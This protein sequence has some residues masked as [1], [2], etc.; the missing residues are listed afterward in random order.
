MCLTHAPPVPVQLQLHTNND[1]GEQTNNDTAADAGGASER[2]A[3]FPTRPLQLLPRHIGAVF[4]EAPG[5]SRRRAGAGCKSDVWKPY[6]GE[7]RSGP[8]FTHKTM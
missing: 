5:F 7:G 8:S 4:V 6:G 3:A 2:R 1:M